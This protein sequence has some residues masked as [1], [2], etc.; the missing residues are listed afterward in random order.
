MWVERRE[1]SADK[2]KICFLVILKDMRLLA[3]LELST[4]TLKGNLCLFVLWG[5]FGFHKLSTSSE[6]LS[7]DDDLTLSVLDS[8]TMGEQNHGVSKEEFIRTFTFMPLSHFSTRIRSLLCNIA[9]CRRGL[10]GN[11]VWKSFILI[12]MMMRCNFGKV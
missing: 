4:L 8:C 11:A 6:V 12:S 7:P 3:S 2:L 10:D 9:C 1:E 5:Y